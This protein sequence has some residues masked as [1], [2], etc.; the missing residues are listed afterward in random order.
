MT[1]DAKG[2]SRSKGGKRSPVINLEGIKAEAERPELA[3]T[4][5]SRSGECLHS[6]IVSNDGSFTF[7]ENILEKVHRVRIGPRDAEPDMLG[8]VA[9][10]YRADGFKAAL[11]LGV[12][13][14]GRTIWRNWFPFIRC[15]T[16]RVRV[17]RRSPWWYGDLARFAALPL[18]VERARVSPSIAGRAL[19]VPET[20]GIRLQQEAALVSP[21]R[22][23]PAL[24][25]DG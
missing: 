20:S 6:A 13:N 16:G 9:L 7:L 18:A 21:N 10:T 4:A 11:D 12:I 1:N 3:V 24:S 22:I 17:C 19:N 2:K 14:V 8:E 23:S 25:M 15:V 5:W